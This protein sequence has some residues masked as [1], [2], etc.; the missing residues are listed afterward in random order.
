MK[1]K[2]AKEW[3]E[4]GQ[5]NLAENYSMALYSLNKSLE[6]EPNKRITNLLLACTYSDLANH[7]KALKIFSKITPN[8]SDDDSFKMTYHYYLAQT[9]RYTQ[10]Y[11][12]A[13][14][15]YDRCIKIEPHKTTFYILKG[16]CL[17]KMGNYNLAIK[18]HLKAT[19]LQ[20]NPEEAHYNLA[21]L[22]RAEMKFE[23]AKNHCL[24]SLKIDPNQE[25]VKHCLKDI[26]EVLK[27]KK[28]YK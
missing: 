12:L 14:K 16:A 28:L 13:I 18:N 21:L 17:A 15:H 6:L 11:S 19:K 23:K 24:L 4:I 26:N 3:F 2:S 25:D 27:L 22:Y 1:K 9:Y 8:K 10:K 5:Q 20:G 7:K